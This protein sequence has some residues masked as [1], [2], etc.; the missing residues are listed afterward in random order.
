MMDEACGL[1]AVESAV[2]VFARRLEKP[3]GSV[4]WKL[5]KLSSQ[6][7]SQIVVELQFG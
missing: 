2:H 6:P 4:S 3:F 1:V 7:A 5:A